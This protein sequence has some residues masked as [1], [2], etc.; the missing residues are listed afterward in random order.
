M[1]SQQVIATL[2]DPIW[3]FIGIIITLFLFIVPFLIRKKSRK[4]LSF[5]ILSNTS[6]ISIDD[7]LKGDVSIRFKN[8]SVSDLRLLVFS[9]KNTGN[10]PVLRADY[11][12]QFKVILPYDTQVLSS[13]IFNAS[14]TSLT[15][16]FDEVI[17]SE[18]SEHYF[19][20]EPVLFNPGDQFSFKI[21]AANFSGN[22]KSSVRIV[23]MQDVKN[24]NNSA[25]ITTEEDAINGFNIG[26]G[27][28]FL[29]IFAMAAPFYIWPES[30]GRYLSKSA[31]IIGPTILLT[32]LVGLMT[33]R[34][35]LRRLARHPKFGVALNEAMESL[36]MM[37][38][39]F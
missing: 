12:K 38:S 11:E 24:S 2:R 35:S 9:V 34:F 1:L 21:F 19:Q 20:F 29:V 26:V 33:M 14:P 22:I 18:N 8:E 17:D 7:K 3:Q 25:H 36:P 13:E 10:V 32:S 4:Q 28:L 15:I 31:F 16:S 23:G 5:T 39:N 37:R 30:L 6:L 27:I